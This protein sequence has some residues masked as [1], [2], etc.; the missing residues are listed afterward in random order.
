MDL[1][2]EANALISSLPFNCSTFHLLLLIPYSHSLP[3]Q[4]LPLLTP[5]LLT[6]LL[7]KSNE[8]P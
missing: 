1:N 2:S 6:P 3:L 4:S 7:L 8:Q 5:L